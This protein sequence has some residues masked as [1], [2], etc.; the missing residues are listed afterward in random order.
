MRR[1][2]SKK[3]TTLGL[4]LLFLLSALG[5]A[6]QAR[7]EMVTLPIVSV[8]AAENGC[9]RMNFAAGSFNSYGVL[10]FDA[11]TPGGKNM[12]SIALAAVLAGKNVSVNRMYGGP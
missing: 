10:V 2:R 1:T 4:T 5:F 11:N 3:T 8:A 9:G 6:R 12:L 7:A